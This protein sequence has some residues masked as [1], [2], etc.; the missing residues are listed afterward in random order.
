MPK[1]EVVVLDSA[2]APQ[3]CG[4]VSTAVVAPAIASALHKATGKT[5]RTMPFPREFSSV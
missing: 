4:E 5:Y 3:G 1:V 2:R